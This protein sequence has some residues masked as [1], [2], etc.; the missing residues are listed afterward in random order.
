[1]AGAVSIGPNGVSASE[2]ILNGEAIHASP[3]G[4]QNV[5]LPGP[6]TSIWTG[7]IWTLDKAITV[8]RVEVQAKTAPVLCATNAVIRLTD[9]MSPVDVTLGAAAESSGT[10][11][12]QYAALS[13][14]TVSVVSPAIS[15]TTNPADVNVTI[16]Y[17]MQ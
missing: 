2:F 8:T 15:C 11:A 7:S 1:M 12:Q 9:G 10:I 6:L 16:Q 4:E 13:A 5:F 14:L 17:K 3:R